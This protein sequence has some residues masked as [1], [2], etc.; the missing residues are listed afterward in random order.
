MI[1]EATAHIPRTVTILRVDIL[2]PQ[3]VLLDS[4]K[5]PRAPRPRGFGL[6]HAFP[7]ASSPV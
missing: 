5:W 4:V 3:C 6:D 1:T 2:P 7:S